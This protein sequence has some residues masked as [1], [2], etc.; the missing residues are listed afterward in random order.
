[1]KNQSEVHHDAVLSLL[2]FNDDDSFITL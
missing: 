2:N 1:L